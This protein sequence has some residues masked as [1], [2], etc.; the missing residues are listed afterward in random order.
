MLSV[1]VSGK[2]AVALGW[3]VLKK[4]DIT[5][6]RICIRIEPFQWDQMHVANVENAFASIT[7]T[8][9]IDFSIRVIWVDTKIS[10]Q[11]V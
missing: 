5:R 7:V 9:F 10:K 8:A 4:L 1:D 6:Q 11:L 2:F 3:N